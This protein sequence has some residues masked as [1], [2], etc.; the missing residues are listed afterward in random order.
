[1]KERMWL[2][3]TCAVAMLF[4]VPGPGIAETLRE[5]FSGALRIQ[6]GVDD[7]GA[8]K[9]TDCGELNLYNVGNGVREWRLE[10]TCN[11]LSHVIAAPT[12][13]PAPTSGPATPT[14][15]PRATSSADCPDGFFSKTSSGFSIPNITL[16]VGRLYRFCVDLPASKYSYF[17]IY[18][19]NKANTSCSDL[20]VSTISPSGREN[21]DFGP[22][23]VVRSATETGRWNIEMFLHQ[24]CAR[25]EFQIPW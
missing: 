17:E 1:M 9:F 25:Y 19:I 2:G 18:T 24:G 11:Q 3:L 8:P 4:A 5:R 6:T 20:E 16:E 22:A 13:S 14:P 7:F 15:T 23:P 12:P 10:N 21:F